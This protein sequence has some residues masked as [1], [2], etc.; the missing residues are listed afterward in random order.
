VALGVLAG[1]P[2]AVEVL[3]VDRGGHVV[4]TAGELQGRSRARE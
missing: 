1:A 4:G 2:V 3:V